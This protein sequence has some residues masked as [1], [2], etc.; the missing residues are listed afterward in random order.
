MGPALA[1]HVDLGQVLPHHAQAEHDQAPDED[2]HADQGS[3][4]GYRVPLINLRRTITISM[5]KDTPVM[6]KPIQEDRFKG[7]K[8]K[9]MIPS[10]AYLA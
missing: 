4:A 3:P 7:T 5:I 1:F 8:E 10:M 9:L 6:K 2:H